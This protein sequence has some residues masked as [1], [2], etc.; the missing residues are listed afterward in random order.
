MEPELRQLRYFVAVAQS[1]NYTR[2]A[3]ALHIA[4]PAL[5]KQIRQLERTLRVQ[6]FD[7]T[8][9]RVV[10]TDA[11][12]ALLPYAT[13][14]LATATDARTHMGD[15]SGSAEGRVTV[16]AQQSLNASGMLPR[17]LVEFHERYPGVDVV[18]REEFAAPT[19]AMLADG[20]LDLALAM[21]DETWPRAEDMTVEPLF[22][23]ELVFVVGPGH[24]L[25][26]SSVA[27]RQLL[28]EPFVA[29]N[30]G[31][32]LR[33]IL[34]RACAD[35][36]FQPRIG[37]ES[38]ATGSVR[39]LASA[40]LG[41][42]LLPRPVVDVD[43]PPLAPLRTDVALRRTISLIRAYERYQSA[44]SRALVDLFRDRLSHG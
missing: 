36:G 25:A 13:R 5:S 42:A 26:G 35:A 39:A 6:L 4:Q 3:D 44:A 9:R 32:G 12:Q 38:G 10:L 33:R 28:L 16:S 17:V 31:A 1:L 15:L 11:G 40:G 22:D 23:E 30:R 43:G 7:R 20:R 18:L 24:R 29:F 14:I 41:V 34:E 21:F 37:Y 19:M 27:L 2:A 8:S